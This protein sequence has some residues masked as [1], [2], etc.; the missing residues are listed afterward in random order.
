MTGSVQAPSNVNAFDTEFLRP[1]SGSAT[2][3][4]AALWGDREF[5]FSDVLDA[6]NPLQH[7]PIVS[8]IYRKLTGDEIAVGP[9]LLGG[10]LFGGPI[11]LIVAGFNAMVEGATGNDVG[12][13]VVALFEDAGGA[14]EP[15]VEMATAITDTDSANAPANSAN[16]PI[17]PAA[18]NPARIPIAAASPA[19]IGPASRANPVTP[20]PSLETISASPRVAPASSAR[21]GPAPQWFAPSPPITNA[22]SIRPSTPNSTTG[23]LAGTLA[24]IAPAAGTRKM[25]PNAP[26]TVQKSH[27]ELVATALEMRAATLARAPTTSPDARKEERRHVNMPPSEISRDW[28]AQAMNRAL[29]KYRRAGQLGGGKSLPIPTVR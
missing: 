18:M 26:F 29:D 19:P 7:I 5:S 22:A 21:I 20:S 23:R 17:G 3:T 16:A 11:G 28:Y 1:E 9:R 6:I 4:L 13:H 2:T 25:V 12:D 10:A 15:S 27:A 24:R 14:S 8:T